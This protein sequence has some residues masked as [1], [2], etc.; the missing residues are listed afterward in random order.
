MSNIRLQDLTKATSEDISLDDVIVIDVVAENKTK[1][2]TVGELYKFL[3]VQALK[4]ELVVATRER[5]K[6]EKQ[7][8]HTP[9]RYIQ[10]DHESNPYAT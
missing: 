3:Q 7:L 4:D 1:G 9:R 5:E 6:L 2:I 10:K 8:R